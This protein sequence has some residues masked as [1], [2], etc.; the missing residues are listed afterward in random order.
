MILLSRSWMTRS[1][2]L[3]LAALFLVC[4]SRALWAQ[5][6]DFGRPFGLAAAPD[7][8]L[9]VS[10]I[11]WHVVYR[12]DREGS[13]SVLA[14]A[15]EQAGRR[16]GMPGQSRLQSPGRIASALDG[17]LY[18]VEYGSLRVRRI[19][20]SGEVTTLPARLEA[21]P[22]GTA[23]DED[24]QPLN[25]LAGIAVDGKGNVYV[26]DSAANV[27]WRIA[28]N[29][30][31]KVLAGAPS[32]AG[33]VD[34]PGPE[35]RFWN[36]E[37][38]ACTEAGDV[39]ISDRYNR[40]IRRMRPDG[41]VVTLAG[42]AGATGS[43]DGKATEARF[44]NPAGIVV[45][46]DGTILVADEGNQVIRT[47]SPAGA[48]ATIAGKAGVP[49]VFSHDAR[50]NLWNPSALALS[51][52]GEL[53]VISGGAIRRVRADGTSSLLTGPHGIPAW[54]K[55]PTGVGLTKAGE[56]LVADAHSAVVW[57]RGIDG[58]IVVLAGKPGE[59]GMRDGP[60][61]EARF[62]RPDGLAVGPDGEVYVADVGAH[63][64]RV[65]T[66]SGEVRTAAGVL[67]RAGAADGP[68]GVGLLDEPTKVAVAPDRTLYIVEGSHN[69]I[70]RCGPN[71]T[72]YTLAGT[73]AA[74]TQDGPGRS[75][76][77]D[78][79]LGVALADSGELLV[80][81][82]RNRLLLAVSTAGDVRT[83]LGRKD[84]A[85]VIDG[86]AVDARFSFPTAL[87][88]DSQGAL[89][90]ADSTTIRVWRQ[91]R[92]TTV[93]GTRSVNA[94]EDGDGAQARFGS[95]DGLAFGA[96]GTLYAADRGCACIRTVTTR[97][98]VGTIAGEFNTDE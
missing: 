22:G 33:A 29:G 32:E 63:A 38:L 27:I 18:F 17:T 50:R 69:R 34:G 84:K 23:E 15:I 35:A 7:G 31:A 98:N 28:G 61:R 20:P 68:R 47:I 41:S 85:S 3:A 30:K 64:I 87:A 25:N 19:A 13:M 6:L 97:G 49:E 44:Y 1:L 43:A 11:R 4:P 39:I 81:D 42:Q 58:E 9:F 55:A 65:I 52:S 89:W 45:R 66:P 36:P 10:D 74:G 37:E 95:I 77:F 94:H 60:A 8:G 83:L 2:R 51:R 79:P 86:D 12:I 70:R 88:F 59:Q 93:A 62:S 67:G 16:D 76:T 48:V 82:G 53:F 73:P 56:L 92:L 14:G 71:G 54:F 72:I 21:R 40:T 91:G 57:K 75:A 24:G 46:A 90:I 5:A 80:A 26:S 96:D 78:W